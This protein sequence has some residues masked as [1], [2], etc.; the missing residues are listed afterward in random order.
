MDQFMG[1]TMRF[2]L[3]HKGHAALRAL[4]QEAGG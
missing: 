1:E 2:T 3:N 4:E